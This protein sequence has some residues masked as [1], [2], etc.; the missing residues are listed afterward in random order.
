MGLPKAQ[1]L[2]AVSE[3]LETEL[4]E[5]IRG[6]ARRD[7]H[8]VGRFFDRY[9][10]EVNR[11][12]WSLLGADPEHD[13]VVHACF[14]EMLQN[15]GRVGRAIALRGWVRAVT[16]NVVRKTIRARRWRRLFA[17]AEEGLERF[18][19]HVPDERQRETI[20]GVYRALQKLPDNQRLA[21]VLRHVEGYELSELAE[22]LACSLASAKRLLVRAEAHFAKRHGPWPEGSVP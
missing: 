14:S 18:D 2:K 13:D 22:A 19:P 10:G 3:A 1:H 16:V 5:L 11:I 17:P 20:R 8:A 9:E 15:V 21:L 12:V 6:V 7:R 4:A